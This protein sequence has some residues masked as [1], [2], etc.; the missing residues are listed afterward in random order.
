[1]K[2]Q[3]GIAWLLEYYNSLTYKK[4]FCNKWRQFLKKQW[5]NTKS[6]KVVSYMQA[7]TEVLIFLHK[8]V[9]ND[10]YLSSNCTVVLILSIFVNICQHVYPV[11]T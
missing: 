5:I 10:I 4:P 9:S 6:E 1:M 2:H 3:I 7:S 8:T 11:P